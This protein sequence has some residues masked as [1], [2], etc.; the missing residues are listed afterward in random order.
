MRK[1]SKS[2]DVR[3][4]YGFKIYSKLHVQNSIAQLVAR[5]TYN[6]EIQGSIPAQSILEKILKFIPQE[7][8]VRSRLAALHFENAS[9]MALTNIQLEFTCIY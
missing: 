8:G 3:A 1:I 7:S 9:L 6:S 5:W 2:I 4:T